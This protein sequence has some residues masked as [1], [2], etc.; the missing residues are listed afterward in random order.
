M[1]FMKVSLNDIKF[2]YPKEEAL[3]KNFHVS[4]KKNEITCL[5]GQNGSGK[6]TILKLILGAVSASEGSVLFDNKKINNTSKKSRLIGYIPQSYSLDGEMFVKDIIPFIASLHGLEKNNIDERKAFLE[7]SLGLTPFF[8]KQ[9]KKLSGG[10]KQLVNIAIGLTHNPEILLLDE[11]FVGLDFNVKLNLISFLKSL[12]KTIICVTHDIDLAERNADTII[13]LKNGKI[14]EQS[15][16]AALIRKHPY[17]TA[18]IDFKE[19]V[20]LNNMIFK[21]EIYVDF[22]NRRATLFCKNTS[23]MSEEIERFK[24]EHDAF[25]IGSRV[26][27]NNLTST[28]MGLH[29]ISLSNLKREKKVR[30]KK[31]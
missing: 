6:S 23:L 24:K 27:Q 28:L 17:I 29:N 10:Q 1:T 25:I 5:L 30:K 11:P 15:K 19:G 16:P 8:N 2:K 18:E 9:I 21:E 31:K 20:A 22:Q 4:I 26:S 14:L 7:H 12:N 13:L 3:F